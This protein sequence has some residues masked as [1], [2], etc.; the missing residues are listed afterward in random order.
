[1]DCSL[2]AGEGH[3]CRR[4]LGRGR[5]VPGQQQQ[6]LGASGATIQLGLEGSQLQIL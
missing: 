3:L 5:F 4:L 1:M 6:L 2:E